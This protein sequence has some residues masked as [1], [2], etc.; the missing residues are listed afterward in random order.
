MRLGI[1]WGV[2]VGLCV[3]GG[4]CVDTEICPC[5]YLMMHVLVL[6]GI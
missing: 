3:T 2:G 5:G 6:D 1:G 4:W